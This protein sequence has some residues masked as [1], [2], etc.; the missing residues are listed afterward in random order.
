MP[1][2]DS[3]VCNQRIFIINESNGDKNEVY[4]ATVKPKSLL[5]KTSMLISRSC[6]TLCS[7]YKY[8][9]LIGGLIKDKSFNEC[10]KYNIVDDKWT[11]L[12]KLNI[13]R[14]SC[15]AFL[16]QNYIY[17]FGGYRSNVVD[18]VLSSIEKLKANAW[19]NI[20]ISGN[21]IATGR[22]H[23][24][25]ISDKSAIV[26]GGGD[27]TKDTYKLH[28]SKSNIAFSKG[29]SM[30]RSCFFQY[31]A[32]PLRIDDEVYVVDYGKTIHKYTIST[33]TWESI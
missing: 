4:E 30:D 31:T 28:I 6:F 1:Y 22:L 18:S 14:H 21:Y 20:N 23:G 13:N 8:I 2:A 15:A 10:D 9:F 29:S 32:A 19:E 16:H 3:I 26:F 25:S 24:I 33:N 27:S 7:K 17:V 5:K 12:P 11:A